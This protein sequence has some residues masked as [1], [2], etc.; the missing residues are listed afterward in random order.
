[1]PANNDLI[2]SIYDL[3]EYVR[4]S[5]AGDPFLSGIKIRGE[6]S[7]FKCYPSGHWYFSL[8]DDKA[9][10]SCVMFRQYNFMHNSLPADGTSVI[11]SGSAT[12]Y[13][14]DGNYQFYAEKMQRDGMGGLFARFML[15]KETLSKEGLFDA[16]VKKPIPLYPRK[17]G[18]A[19]SSSGAVIHDI[20]SVSGRRNPSI[21]LVLYPAAVQGDGAAED[22]ISAIAYLSCLPEVDVI[23]IGRGGGSIEDLWAFNDERLVRAIRA[24]RL[25]VVSAVGHETDF[26]LS[27]FAADARAATPSQAAEM[28]VPDRIG[29]LTRVSELSERLRGAAGALLAEQEQRRSEL[30]LRLVNMRPD[31]KL[32][33]QEHCVKEML[34]RLHNGLVT[35][36][37]GW[38]DRLSNASLKL[39]SLS[40]K[41][42]LDRGYVLVYANG[43]IISR[44][45]EMLPGMRFALQMKD[46]RINARVNQQEEV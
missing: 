24:S 42:V 20:I 5:L 13:T 11:L 41:A 31:M 9:R 35:V 4:K 38:Q 36:L 25:P 3:N 40:P 37:A 1:M 22:I 14:R 16:S 27:D 15:L 12:L 2:L 17:I 39:Y 44:A 26:T 19:T 34:G 23:I 8:K 43:G 28:C 33:E 45:K 21:P 7:G 10:I 29:L 6:I 18:V 30:L 32:A 46:G